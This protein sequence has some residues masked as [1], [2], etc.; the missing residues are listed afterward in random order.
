M[1]DQGNVLDR[2]PSPLEPSA[3]STPGSSSCGAMW[4]AL[5]NVAPL[6]ARVNFF[7]NYND[8]ELNRT[9]WHKNFIITQS[10]LNYYSFWV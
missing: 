10:L 9:G 1:I 8:Q 7:L 2:V 4:Q 3:L 5:E 6:V